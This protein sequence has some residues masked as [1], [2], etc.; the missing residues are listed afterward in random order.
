MN[1]AARFAALARP[2]KGRP[3]YAEKPESVTQTA[4]EARVRQL[5]GVETWKTA[6]TDP[7]IM[8]KSRARVARQ[9]NGYPLG[10]LLLQD[11]AEDGSGINFDQH[12]IGIAYGEMRIR[13]ARIMGFSV[14]HPKSPAFAMVAKETGDGRALDEQ[15]VAHIRRVYGNVRSALSYADQGYDKPTPSALLDAV[16]L[17]D[18]MPDGQR[19]LGRLRVALNVVR[20]AM[21]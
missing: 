7:K 15:V 12:E 17:H 18:Y 3:P 20:R 13:H 2:K 11:D 21:R 14:P 19:E 1:Q 10:L 4:E 5:L 8:R 9:F 6:R 16:V